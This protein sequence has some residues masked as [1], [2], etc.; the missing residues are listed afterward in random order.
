MSLRLL[1]MM[2]SDG[3]LALLRGRGLTAAALLIITLTF[4]VS[5]LALLAAGNL[6]ATVELNGRPGVFRV[7]FGEEAPD[8]EAVELARRLRH[9]DGIASV[10]VVRA[11]QARD[12]FLAAFPE[13]SAGVDLLVDNPFPPHLEV[14]VADAVASARRRE[15]RAALGDEEG[16]VAVLGDDL[17]TRRLLELARLIRRAGLAAG[18]AFALAA[19]LVVAGVTRLSL[20]TRRDE[21][22]VMWVVGA[23]RAFI[24]GPFVVEGVV[25]GAG[26]AL[27][28][29]AASWGV[30]RG[31]SMLAEEHPL[32][33][34]LALAPLPASSVLF[35]VSCSVVAGTAGA[36]LTVHQ[37]ARAH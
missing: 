9:R 25:L 23:P 30:F 17:W 14:T 11:G 37:A 22:A 32:L 15:L 33:G 7:Y 4:S 34:F 29:W 19:T 3:L 2:V 5:A 16:V 31:A 18:L 36:L 26:G 24:S 12:D 13:M 8:S 1:R 20:A 28:A 6:A 10:T 21:I 35:L 27:L